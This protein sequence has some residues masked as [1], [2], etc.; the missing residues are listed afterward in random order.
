MSDDEDISY[1]KKTN[2]IHY[3]SLEETER[4]KQ[5]RVPGG[6]LD[7]IVSDDDDFNEPD[8]K[9]AKLTVAAV[10]NASTNSSSGN[11][12]TSNEYFDLEQE[13]YVYSFLVD[14]SDCN[15]E[16]PQFFLHVS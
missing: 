13:V 10:N 7:E 3:G 4:L 15:Q 6:V 11:V 8:K 16:Y 1:V 5:L 9:V 12:N 14:L 2:T